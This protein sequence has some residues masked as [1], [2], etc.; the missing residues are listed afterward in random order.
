M[1][2]DRL[3]PPSGAAAVQRAADARPFLARRAGAARLLALAS[4]AV[5]TGTLLAGCS[6]NGDAPPA[7]RSSGPLPRS[8][9]AAASS[10]SAAIA[11]TLPQRSAV[12]PV[13]VPSAP[14]VVAAIE[15]LREVVDRHARVPDNPWAVCHAILALGT[16]IQL[17][18]GADAVDF[19]FEAY[20]EVEM[21]GGEP[22]IRFPVTV[23][24]QRSDPHTGVTTTVEILVEPHPDL[25]LKTLAERGLTPSRAVQVA[26]RDLTLGDLY[27]HS[28]YK[29]WVDSDAVGYRHWNNVPWGLQA[30]ATWAPSGL[31]WTAE[32]GRRMT[33]DAYTHACVVKLHEES[34][35][36][37]DAMREGRKPDPGLPGIY[38]YTCG[39][40]HYLQGVGYALARGF[41]E[42]GDRDLFAQQIE[43]LFWGFPH[44]MAALNEGLVSAPR[45]SMP[46]LAQALKY[47]G[48][49]VETTHKFAALE[50]FE[51]TD[52]QKILMVNA[53]GYLIGTMN[54]I[55]QL[56]IFDR[57]DE[58][59]PVNEQLYLDFVGDS[60]HAL[61]GLE[62]ATGR[63]RVAY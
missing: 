35:F 4:M 15:R 57:L 54:Q 8:P 51:P 1:P 49:F 9:V 10:T 26:G 6:G 16:D 61:R 3:T 23:S 12:T 21:I 53:V 47:I 42:A 2:S 5:L 56:E 22:L 62:L 17:T 63:A 39:G 31:A 45:E 44:R 52:A 38:G 59:R 11:W 48:H 18:N 24:R 30:L 37:R 34:G 43:A 29:A 50:L 55:D 25:I 58:V 33:L 60:A 7:A 20:G 40:A 27:R 13:V 36:L 32:G 46:I 14:E 19:L 41:G 28:L